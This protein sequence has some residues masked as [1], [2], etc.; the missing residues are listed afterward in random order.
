MTKATTILQ[1]PAR[2]VGAGVPR[3]LAVG[4]AVIE[5]AS[6]RTAN[7][8]SF[9]RRFAAHWSKGTATGTAYIDVRP[10]SKTATEITVT[11]ERPKGAAG[12]FWPT[13]RRRSL[14]SLFA[15]AIAY[16]VETRSLEES[17]PFEVRR[18]SRELVRARA[19]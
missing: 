3:T 2:K 18:T 10:A 16:E 6:E 1:V 15:N 13:P 7:G 8:G 17:D 12:S 4:P 5:L 14:A 11:V 9:A 19:S